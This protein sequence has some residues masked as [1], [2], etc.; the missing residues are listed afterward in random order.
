MGIFD[1]SEPA[2]VVII[3]NPGTASEERSRSRAII[4]PNS[5][6]FEDTT[7]IYE[8][9]I[10]EVPDPRGGVDRRAVRKVDINESPFGDSLDNIEAH[11]L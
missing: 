7:L 8:R 2:D 3:R 11:W 10:V 9:D 1:H 6:V 5:G 4:L